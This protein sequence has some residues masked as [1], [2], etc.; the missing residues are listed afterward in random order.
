MLCFG[1]EGGKGRGR[2]KHKDIF[3][4]CERAFGVLVFFFFLLILI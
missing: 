2:G 1:K 4:R 3:R